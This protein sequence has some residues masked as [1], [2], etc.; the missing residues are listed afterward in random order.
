M[1]KV[2]VDG[3]RIRADLEKVLQHV[4]FVLPEPYHNLTLICRSDDQNGPVV[5]SNNV[6]EL[7]M[8]RDALD[9]AINGDPDIISSGREG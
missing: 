7:H 2:I 8:D 4:F 3:E 6:R 1:K 9:A 5:V